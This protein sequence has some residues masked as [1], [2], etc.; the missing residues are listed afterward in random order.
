MTTYEAMKNISKEQFIEFCRAL[1]WKAYRDGVNSVDDD[2]W[3]SI[4]MADYDFKTCV[5]DLWK[6]AEAEF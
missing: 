1:Y 5:E 2:P 6:C 3:I 4:N